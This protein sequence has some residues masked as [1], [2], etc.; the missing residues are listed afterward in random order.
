M[1]LEAK[2]GMGVQVLPPG[3]HFT[4]KQIDEICYLN[5]ERLR[6]RCSNSSGQLQAMRGNRQ[7]SVLIRN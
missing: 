2:L 4:V 3:G 5:D 6:H 1:L 7:P